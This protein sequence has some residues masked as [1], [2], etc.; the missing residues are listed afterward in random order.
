MIARRPE[1]GDVG[2]GTAGAESTEGVVGVVQP[3]VIKRL[4]LAVH[5]L[6]QHTHHLTLQRRERLGGLDLDQI[7]IERGDDLNGRD[8][9]DLWY[10]YE[11][12]KD[13]KALDTLLEYNRKDVVNLVELEKIL[14]WKYEKQR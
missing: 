7:L 13:L 4:S 1:G 11:D 8:A 6:V 12:K 10:K 14:E 3:I 9:I 5:Q 2:D